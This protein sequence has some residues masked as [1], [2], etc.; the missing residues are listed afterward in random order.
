MLKS[1]RKL[2]KKNFSCDAEDGQALAEFIMLIPI[3]LTLLWYLVH[4]GVVVNKS[5]VGQKH[6]R[7]QLFLKMYNHRFG[8]TTRDNSGT[9]RSVFYIG[10]SSNVVSGNSRPEAPTETLGLGIN[11]KKS[12]EANDDPG[13]A[14]ANVLRQKVRVRTVFGICTNRKTIQSGS[15]R[16]LT[17]FCGSENQGN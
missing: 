14:A 1:S 5:I 2:P 8:P 13:E 7:S 16:K 9:D 4:V 10:V 3:V 15:E 12:E 6:A 17:D 11:P